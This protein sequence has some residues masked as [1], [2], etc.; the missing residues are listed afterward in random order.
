MFG[1]HGRFRT[2]QLH[3][4]DVGYI[5]QGYG[6][7]IENVGSKPSWILI[8]FNTGIYQAIDLSAWIAGNP[9]MFSQRILA[10]RHPCSKSSRAKTF[11]FHRINKA[12]SN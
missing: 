7:S 8:G 2:G 5:P 12:L 3:A 11:S 1:S 9:L 4:G 10:S 6:H